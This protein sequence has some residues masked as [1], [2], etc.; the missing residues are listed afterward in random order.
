MITG[1][2]LAPNLTKLMIL[3]WHVV[4][5]VEIRVFARQKHTKIV[6]FDYVGHLVTSLHLFN[7]WSLV[8][9][10]DLQVLD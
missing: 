2:F 7:D 10:I 8:E 1:D 6:V 5:D 3:K 4:G 9:F